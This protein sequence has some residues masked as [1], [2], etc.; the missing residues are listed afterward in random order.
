MLALGRPSLSPGNNPWMS[1][2]RLS[3]VWM[4]PRFD[5]QSRWLTVVAEARVRFLGEIDAD[6]DSV[7]RMVSRR[8]KRHRV[9]HFCYD[10]GPTGYG[11]YRLPIGMGHRCTS[12]PR[13]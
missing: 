1:M 9:L 2:V 4:S 7:R 10:T 3:L 12:S 5:T 11:L 13:H 8:E 6:P